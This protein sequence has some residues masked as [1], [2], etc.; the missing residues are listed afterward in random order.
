VDVPG[1]NIVQLCCASSE[2]KWRDWPVNR[3]V[4]RVVYDT[5]ED[6][7]A[8]LSKEPS[9]TVTAVK[10]ELH[11]ERTE[12][13]PDG[14]DESGQADNHFVDSPN[15]DDIDLT[16]TAAPIATEEISHEKWAAGMLFARLYKRVLSRRSLEKAKQTTIQKTYESFFKACLEVSTNIEWPPRST[17]KMVFLGLVPHLLTCINALESYAS[18]AKT[19]IKRRWEEG[20]EDVGVLDTERTEVTYVAPI[21]L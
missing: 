6:I 5:M 1:E 20:K 4:T 18:K 9:A 2:A 3:G 16:S 11:A 13:M 19:S 10:D 21:F 8:L 12:E 7:P 14:A 15:E 17:Y